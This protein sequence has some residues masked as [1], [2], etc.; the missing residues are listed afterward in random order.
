M[1]FLLVDAL[2]PDG[3][4][5][6]ATKLAAMSED[7]F[8][9]HFPE[10]PV[11]PGVLILE[12]ATQAA[13]WWSAADSDFTKWLLLDRVHSARYYAFATPGHRIGLALQRV[14]SEDPSRAR[15]LVECD[16]DGTRSATLEFEGTLVALD[17]LMD[18]DDARRRYAQL[19]GSAEPL[20]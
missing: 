3:E 14:A 17:G 10:R 20:A 5:L 15:F 1:R 18:P 7:Y 8:E 9:W 16:V 13:G 11:V 2:R 12:A 19:T 6:H 4:T